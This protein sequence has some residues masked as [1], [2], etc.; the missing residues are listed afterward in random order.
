MEAQWNSL[1]R[2]K[3]FSKIFSLAWF[4]LKKPCEIAFLEN[5]ISFSQFLVI[6]QAK[7]N[8]FENALFPWVTNFTVLLLMYMVPRFDKKKFHL[9]RGHVKFQVAGA[10]L[11]TQIFNPIFAY[12]L[13]IPNITTYVVFRKIDD[14]RGRLVHPR[15]YGC[16][17]GPALLFYLIFQIFGGLALYTFEILSHRTNILYSCLFVPF[18]LMIEIKGEHLLTWEIF[19]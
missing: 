10:P 19:F 12:I 11:R 16:L 17:P 1:L 14:I 5:K 8:I 3:V 15:A 9:K 6:P 18:S 13:S 7:M 4:M 2:K